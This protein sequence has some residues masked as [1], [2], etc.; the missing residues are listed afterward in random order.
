MTLF[1]VMAYVYDEMIDICKPGDFIE[2]TGIFRCSPIRINPRLRVVKS[3]YRGY[4]DANSVRTDHL[5][6]F[7]IPVEEMEGPAADG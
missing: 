2:L 7:L 6:R 3:V 1:A 5:N 4:I